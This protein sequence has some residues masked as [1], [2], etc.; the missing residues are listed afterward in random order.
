MLTLIRAFVRGCKLLILDEATSSLDLETDALVQNLIQT[1][2]TDVTVHS[3]SD[4]VLDPGPTE[5]T[6]CS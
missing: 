2:F 3:V 6:P 5:L 1:A 4:T